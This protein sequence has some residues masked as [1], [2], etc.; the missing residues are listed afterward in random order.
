[1]DGIPTLVV[2]D[3]ELKLITA[4]GTAAVAADPEG[5]N[6]PWR[7]KP[8][9]QLSEGTADR[10]NGGPVLLA[11]YD[12]P[13]DDTAV[14]QSAAEALLQPLAEATKASDGG[15]D[16]SFMYVSKADDIATRLLAW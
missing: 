12:T 4:N 5:G 11:V 16:W 10:I 9:E 2:L 1:M 8:V 15:E 7:P 13:A 14:L 6:F 3:E